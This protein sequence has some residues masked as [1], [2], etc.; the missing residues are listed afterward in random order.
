MFKK[1][2][3]FANDGFPYKGTSYLGMIQIRGPPG[4]E[5]TAWLV[6]K[7]EGDLRCMDGNPGQLARYWQ[8]EWS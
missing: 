5:S 8:L 3:L 6:L 1:N 2:A 7:D 4:L